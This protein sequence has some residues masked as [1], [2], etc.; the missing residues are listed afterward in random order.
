MGAEGGFDGHIPSK[1]PPYDLVAILAELK[2]A[3]QCTK[4]VH[5]DSGFATLIS[6]AMEDAGTRYETFYVNTLLNK[7]QALESGRGVARG[8]NMT[9]MIIA[10]MEKNTTKN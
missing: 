9:N 1:D 6:Q 3:S 8:Q 5:G 7:Q 10:Q 2:L 4:L